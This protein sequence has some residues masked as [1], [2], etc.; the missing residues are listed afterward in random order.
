[1]SK[2]ILKTLSPLHIGSGEEFDENYNLLYKDGFVYIFDEFKIVE[3]LISKN[4]QIPNQIEELK[5]IIVSNKDELIQKEKYKRKIESKFSTISKPLF[6]QISTQNNPII[7]G[8]SIKGAIK[9]AYFNK[10]IKDGKFRNEIENLQKLDDDIYNADFSKKKDL[11]R[12]KKRLIGDIDRK[13]INELK[14]ESK[15]LKIS[16]SFTSIKTKICKSI[17]IK[18]EKSHQS[19]RT[20]KVEQISNFIE[21]IS[22]QQ[23]IFVTIDI[24]SNSIDFKNLVQVCNDFYK[25]EY[26]KEF[27]NYFLDKVKFIK[28]KEV[29]KNQFLLNIGRFGGAELKSVEE[30]REL[31]RTGADVSWETSARNYAQEKNIQDKIH[32]ENSLL[33]FGWLLCE[34][35]E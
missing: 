6:E 29:G 22:E 2:L 19:S 1:M 8:S 35:V 27:S 21:C 16:D 3:F 17:N 14:N 5:K 7:S 23:E 11:E 34:I 15:Y 9:T 18:K 32:F 28:V 4:I 12:N 13:F 31:P 30:L 20:V 33:P 26:E 24:D 25:N 10:L